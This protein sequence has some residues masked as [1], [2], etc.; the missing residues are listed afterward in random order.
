MVK[1]NIDNCAAKPEK[2][3]LPSRF[4]Y[5][6]LC[7]RNESI[8]HVFYWTLPEKK[9]Y[10]RLHFQQP[11]CPNCTNYQVFTI[12]IDKGRKLF[13]LDLGETNCR[14]KCKRFEYPMVN[15][16]LKPA[17]SHCNIC[18]DCRYFTEY[19][20]EEDR[21]KVK[22]CM[23]KKFQER[24]TFI[25]I[26]DSGRYL[27]AIF[28]CLAMRRVWTQGK[29]FVH[30]CLLFFG[31]CI[32]LISVALEES[33]IPDLARITCLIVNLCDH[34]GFVAII[35]DWPYR[36]L[37]FDKGTIEALNFE[38]TW[39]WSNYI[40]PPI[41]TTILAFTSNTRCTNTNINIQLILQS[42]SCTA[43]LTV[44]VYRRRHY[45]NS[46]TLFISVTNVYASTLAMATLI[47][48]ITME[49]RLTTLV[50]CSVL[51]A[52]HYLEFKRQESFNETHYSSSSAGIVNTGDNNNN[53]HHHLELWRIPSAA[54][55]VV[56]FTNI[57]ICD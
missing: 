19:K 17:C 41:M 20:R 25:L 57:Q 32:R 13:K 51:A 28:I 18:V 45:M 54:L 48:G 2:P 39:L 33:P 42:L 4:L 52:K 8:G 10:Y 53:D 35:V 11:D 46:C 34:L 24:S 43:L 22:F 14:M 1:I 7:I 6:H 50:V 31:L 30:V 29:N 27:L 23:D 55:M 38:L 3:E 15:K 5:G 12:D 36:L 47:G 44:V 56:N 21:A 40:I 49:S 37:Y 16:Q 26:I 9:Q